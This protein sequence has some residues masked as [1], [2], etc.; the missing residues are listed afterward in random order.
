MSEEHSVLFRRGGLRH[1][2][3]AEDLDDPRVTAACSGD[4]AALMHLLQE[5]DPAARALVWAVTGGTDVDDV[6]AAAYARAPQALGEVGGH[7]GFRTWLLRL[8]WEEAARGGASL[9]TQA[10]EPPAAGPETATEQAV[11]WAAMDPQQRA[12]LTLCTAHGLDYDD[13]AAVMGVPAAAVATLV[14]QG[15]SQMRRSLA[16]SLVTEGRP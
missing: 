11:G 4:R 15:R 14:A 1:L 16:E 2:T 3:R 7:V 10:P 13:A 8:C 9:A 5:H 6:L 12:A